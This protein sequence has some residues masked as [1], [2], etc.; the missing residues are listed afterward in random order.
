MRDRFVIE[1][2]DLT[3]SLP[4]AAEELGVARNTVE[5]EILRGELTACE[6]AGRLVVRR[7]DLEAHLA[8]RIE[9]DATDGL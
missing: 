2:D 3:L 1:P 4:K 5:R 6:I 8:T 9:G 7:R